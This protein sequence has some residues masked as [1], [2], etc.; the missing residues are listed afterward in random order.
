M[1]LQYFKSYNTIVFPY[2]DHLFETPSLKNYP[3]VG[4]RMW[5]VGKKRIRSG[6]PFEIIQSS[7]CR[8]PY[9]FLEEQG[10][11]ENGRVVLRST[12]IR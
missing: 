9:I 10:E 1:F 12:V 4:S 3:H 11:R 2:I 7:L 6:N 8:L 5:T